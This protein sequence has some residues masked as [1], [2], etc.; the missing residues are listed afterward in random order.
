MKRKNSLLL[1]RILNA[2]GL[3]FILAVVIFLSSC[4]KNGSGGK[5]QAQSDTL[6]MSSQL[7]DSNTMNYW[8]S[9]GWTHPDSAKRNKFLLL[10]FYSSSAGNINNNMSLIGYPGKDMLSLGA[11]KKAFLTEDPLIV[12]F[13]ATDTVIVANNIANLDSLKLF[14]NQGHRKY[15]LVRFIPYKD[16]Y[17]YIT[18]TVELVRYGFDKIV[19]EKGTNPCPPCQYCN[20]PSCTEE[21]FE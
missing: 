17:H 9:K 2:A 13:T 1:K 15:D 6:Y 10:Q 12:K 18:F 8:V 4:D 14:D 3:F 21:Y 5:A 16:M 19:V 20:P 7:L 11:R